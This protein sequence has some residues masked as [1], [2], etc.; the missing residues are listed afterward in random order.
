MAEEK[1]RLEEEAEAER[2]AAKQ[3]EEEEEAARLEEEA[4]KEQEEEEQ[5]KKEEEVAEGLGENE[6][7]EA[8]AELAADNNNREGEVCA[9]NLD[10][11]IFVS[12]ELILP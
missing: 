7:K 12:K 2:A 4:R 3:K 1:K 11:L 8:D 9:S 10:A 6:G 5:E